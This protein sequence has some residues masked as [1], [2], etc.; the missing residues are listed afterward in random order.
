M[1]SSCCS[2]RRAR[3]ARTLQ[4]Q[5]PSDNAR[6]DFRRIALLFLCARLRNDLFIPCELPRMRF[7]RTK[8]PRNAVGAR[9]GN[10]SLA[11]MCHT[12]SRLQ[13]DCMSNQRRLGAS[14]CAQ[15]FSNAEPIRIPFLNLSSMFSVPRND[16]CTC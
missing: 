9:G 7:C 5:L 10:I 11:E 16:L 15:V 1:E 14:Q 4:Q 12:W 13:H 2:R 8:V 6:S 3:E